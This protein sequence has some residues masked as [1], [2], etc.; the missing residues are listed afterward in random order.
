[1][2][3]FKGFQGLD[4]VSKRFR[5]RGSGFSGVGFRATFWVFLQVVHLLSRLL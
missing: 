3:F 1:M 2:E 5:V 4:R